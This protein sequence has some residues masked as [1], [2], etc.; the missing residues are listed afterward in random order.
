MNSAEKY[1]MAGKEK[2]CKEQGTWGTA[3]EV[4]EPQEGR[5]KKREKEGGSTGY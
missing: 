4:G 5:G 2:V 1:I 3:F